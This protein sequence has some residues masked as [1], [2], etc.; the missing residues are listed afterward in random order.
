MALWTQYNDSQFYQGLDWAGLCQ[1]AGLT[2]IIPLWWALRESAPCYRD[3][4]PSVREPPFS[5]GEEG[6]S[7]VR[8][9]FLIHKAQRTII[10]GAPMPA[11]L[12]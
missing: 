10:R 1:L 2:A 11:G 8:H 9:P 3:F 4:I 5:N 12:R 6:F 7:Y